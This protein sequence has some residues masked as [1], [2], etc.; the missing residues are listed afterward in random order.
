MT[1][2]ITI[3]RRFMEA[4][5][6]TGNAAAFDECLAPDIVVRTGLS[7]TGPIEGLEAYKSIFVPFAKALPV[8]DFE[9]LE[10]WENEAENKVVVRFLAT[11]VFLSDF[12]GVKAEHQIVAMEEVHILTFRNGK[13]VSNV[14]SGTNFPFEYLMYPVLK[15]AILGAMRI[16]SPDEVERA[17]ASERRVG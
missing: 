9:I 4:G 13:I 1:D 3:A 5:I 14:V 8:I 2:H 12:Y 15:D 7:P 16:A 6:A 17:R 10:L 11:T